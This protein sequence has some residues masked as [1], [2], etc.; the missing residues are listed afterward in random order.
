MNADCKHCTPITMTSVMPSVGALLVCNAPW[1]NTS[2]LVW[3]K[4]SISAR[5]TARPAVCC[6]AVSRSP[7]HCARNPRPAC[8]HALAAGAGRCRVASKLKPFALALVGDR[9]H[10]FVCRTDVDILAPDVVE[11][12]LDTLAVRLAA[13]SLKLQQRRLQARLRTFQDQFALE[14]A[15]IGNNL[16]FFDAEHPLDELRHRRQVQTIRAAGCH[17]VHDDP[18]VF[19]ID[20]DLNFIANDA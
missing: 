7:R 2:L 1:P 6:L 15:A 12:R 4:R 5:V 18:I 19:C 11:V 10:Y 16:Q 13:R 14:S 9:H 17:L 20:R 8:T 3:S